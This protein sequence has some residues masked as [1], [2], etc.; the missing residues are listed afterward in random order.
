MPDATE[1][2]IYDALTNAGF[3]MTQAAGLMGNM[4]NESS[5]NVESDAIDSNGYPA[6][7]LI[8]WNEQSYPNAGTLVTG[9]QKKDLKDQI[10]YLKTNTDNFKEG[11][12]GNSAEAV[13]GNFA[14]YVEVC[15][16]C[17]PG[18]A[19]WTARRA[20]AN[21]IYSDAKAG[22]W[23][24][25]PGV[26]QS[27]PKTQTTSFFSSLADVNS[28]F[29]DLISA[30]FWE[31]AG[32]ILFGAILVIVGIVILAGG[33]GKTAQNAAKTGKLA[34]TLTGGGG[35]GPSPQQIADRQAR[36][37]IAQRNTALGERRQAVR[38]QAEARRERHGTGHLK[39]AE[40]KEKRTAEHNERQVQIKEQKEARIAS[41]SKK[42]PS[43]KPVSH[44][45]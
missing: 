11:I 42:R 16:G 6:V 14:Q 20:N 43:P 35:S 37:Q 28:F 23:P 26:E 15:Q 17:A 34:G 40:Q 5:F 13:A 4:E 22:K 31:R 7:G 38:E 8:S 30:D 21:Q 25:G 39:L 10:N 29:G 1:K 45:S 2:T 24:S 36:L 32:L 41:N 19:Q 12:Q 27:N 3:S 18:G 9:N 33:P 44:S